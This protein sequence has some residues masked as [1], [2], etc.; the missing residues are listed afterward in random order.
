VVQRDAAAL[1]A[2]GRRAGRGQPA[3][4]QC[5]RLHGRPVDGA[6]AHLDGPAAVGRR[7]RDREVAPEVHERA[8]AERRDLGRDAVGRP[9]LGGGAE[10][11]LDTGRKGRHVAV[12][13]HVAPR[14]RAQRQG[15][16]GRAVLRQV[17]EGAVVAGRPQRP[18]QRRHDEAV[19]LLGDVER[20]AQRAGQHRAHAGAATQPHQLRVGPE[21]AAGEVEGGELGPHDQLGVVE[22]GRLGHED[23]HVGA[24][25]AEP[26]V[27][28]GGREQRGHD[29][30]DFVLVVVVVVVVGAV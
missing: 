9:G 28:P 11:E 15:H 18:A 16:R 26:H 10:V 3:L 30:E 2:P 17:G 4:V 5:D 21:A 27:G 1:P 8:G 13:A 14:V 19:G 25:R 24:D 29:P 23:V 12:E 22:Q 20:G 7:A 6:V